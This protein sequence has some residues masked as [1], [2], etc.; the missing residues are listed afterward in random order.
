VARALD[1]VLELLGK[2]PNVVARK[3]HA[4]DLAE[5][6][7]LDEEDLIRRLNSKRVVS[8]TGAGSGAAGTGARKEEWNP[9]L[10][11]VILEIFLA[12]PER[13]RERLAQIPPD[14]LSPLFP[15]EGT[16]ASSSP[17]STEEPA[18][19]RIGRMV[20]EQ[21]GGGGLDLSRLR[22]DL[23][24]DDA[25]GSLRVIQ[26]RIDREGTSGGARSRDFDW[27]ACLRDVIRKSLESRKVLLG[28]ELDLVLGKD[29]SR[30]RELRLEIFEVQRRLKG[31]NILGPT[32]GSPPLERALER[33]SENTPEK[34]PTGEA[35]EHGRGGRAPGHVQLE[36]HESGNDESGNDTEKGIAS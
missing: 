34:I 36:N 27:T 35:R 13:A 5:R 20:E 3:L 15:P 26:A 21:I 29:E 18:I 10:G 7:G 17:F 33:T 22:R 16:A 24:D 4:K 19:M 28:Q 25:Q 1:E 32:R 31:S 2:L 12:E 6:L 9:S 23:E 14:V 11:E 8:T 30:A